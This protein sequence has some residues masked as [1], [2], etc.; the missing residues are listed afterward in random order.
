MENSWKNFDCQPRIGLGLI[1]HT[2]INSVHRHH[3]WQVLEEGDFW[4][5]DQVKRPQSGNVATASFGLHGTEF[6]S[7]DWWM[8]VEQYAVKILGCEPRK[9]CDGRASGAKFRF[10]LLAKTSRNHE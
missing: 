6:K 7:I 8:K 1:F 5:T 4:K 3:P 9:M 10:L 2:G